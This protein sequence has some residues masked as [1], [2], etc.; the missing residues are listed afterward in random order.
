MKGEYDDTLAWPFTGDVVVEILNWR[1]HKNHQKYTISFH[2]GLPSASI[3][4]V[5]NIDI[6]Q[7]GC[8]QIIP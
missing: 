2:K 5:L 8:Q 6:A 3:N 1:E 7:F 4:R